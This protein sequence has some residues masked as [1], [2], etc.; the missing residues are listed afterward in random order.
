VDCS[1]STP[2]CKAD[3]SDIATVISGAEALVKKAVVDC[4]ASNGPIACKADA[5]KALT[6]STQVG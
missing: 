1:A 3:I 5:L 2:E 6:F 4:K